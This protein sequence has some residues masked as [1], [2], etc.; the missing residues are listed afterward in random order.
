MLAVN[1]FESGAQLSGSAVVKALPRLQ[2]GLPGPAERSGLIAP[3]SFLVAINGV[4]TLDLTFEETIDRLRREKRPARLRFLNSPQPYENACQFAE[5]LQALSP[6]SPL[7]V[8]RENRLLPWVDT[9]RGAF[10]I[11][12]T[13]LFRQ[14][15]D[16]IHVERSSSISGDGAVSSPASPTSPARLERPL[17]T[18]DMYGRQPRRRSSILAFSVKFDSRTFC[19]AAPPHAR[20]FLAEFT[21]TQSF[22][23]FINDGVLGRALQQPSSHPTG[24]RSNWS[25]LELFRQCV[26][27]ALEASDPN[28]G[29][30]L[31]FQREAT[32]VEHAVVHLCPRAGKKEVANSRRT[33]DEG[34]EA[35]ASKL[36]APAGAVDRVAVEGDAEGISHGPET[37]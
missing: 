5:R 25:T 13:T 9:A 15:R 19:S 4:S 27:L 1:N 10:A 16:Y 30:S 22:A 11:L 18:P 2:N 24:Q 6:L 32:P 7:Q 21:Q 3:G 36:M 28:E 35:I 8:D 34:E 20:P 17:P 33:G 31:L 12:F 23:D 14:Y 26:H 29:I 37:E